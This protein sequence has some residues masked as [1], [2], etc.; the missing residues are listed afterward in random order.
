MSML[1]NYM[2]GGT[3][4]D[5][6]NSQSSSSLGWKSVGLGEGKESINSVKGR[7]IE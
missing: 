4:L 2:S 5:S 6:R 1:K 3:S 7:Y